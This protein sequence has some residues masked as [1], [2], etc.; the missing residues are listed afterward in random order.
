MKTFRDILLILALSALTATLVNALSPNGIPWIGNWD[1]TTG[2]LSAGSNRL[3]VD[4]DFEIQTVGEA[5]EIYQ[6]RETLFVDARDMDAYNEGHIQ[7]AISIPVGDYDRV[8]PEIIKTYHYDQP[9]VVYC[10]GR[11]CDDSLK[12]GH[13]LKEDGYTRVR[14]FIDG[15]P[16]WKE[17]GYPV[18]T[19]R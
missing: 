1:K 2:A 6:G 14:V 8:F 9:I 7:G 12:L 10:S 16:A 5:Y 15:F 3:A 13:Y 11:E 17:R 18:E 4:E 19:D